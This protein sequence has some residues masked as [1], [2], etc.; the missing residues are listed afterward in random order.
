MRICAVMKYPPI[1][2]GVSARCYWLARALAKRGHQVHVVTNAGEVE[3]SYRIWICRRDRELLEASFDNGGRVTV[4][5]SGMRRRE[6]YHI[7]RSNP[8]ASKLAGLATEVVR[9]E[10]CDVLFSYYYEPYGLSGHLA[11]LWSGV[12]HV[13]QHAGS[14]QGRLLNHPELS[15]AYREMLRRAAMVV[16]PSHWLEG[17][18]IPPARLAR[19]GVN[20]LPGRHFYPE[21]TTMDVDAVLS[22]LAWHPFVRNTSPWRADL[23]TFG[24]LGKVA[25]LKGSY[26]LVAALARLRARGEE[27]NLLAMVAGADRDRFLAAVDDA[28][29]HQRTWTL[30]LLPHWHVPSFLRACTAVCFLERRFAIPAH[31][32]GIPQEILAC[33]VCAVLSGEI[34]EKQQFRRRLRAGENVLVVEDPTNLDELVAVL[35]LVVRDPDRARAMGA[36]GA[37]L[38]EADGEDELGKAYEALFQAAVEGTG[39]DRSATGGAVR[40]PGRSEDE[41]TVADARALLSRHAPATVRLMAPELGKALEKQRAARSGPEPA[42]PQVAYLAIDEVVREHAADDADPRLEF[43]RFERDV[44]WLAVDLEG[45]AGIPQFPRPAGAPALGP[46]PGGES[47]RPVRSNWLRISA[48]PEGIERA[49]RA[50]SLGA[51]ADL[52]DLNGSERVGYLFH[53]R[54]DLTRHVY[55]VNRATREL[56][57]LCNGSRTIAEIDA[58]LAQR[59]VRSQD[60]TAETIDR[61]EREG[62]LYLW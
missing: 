49:I 9:R 39:R 55:R 25:E 51:E 18:G 38:V 3:D 31:R 45:P 56:I 59:G 40:E 14:D 24:V 44:L 57:E 10:R 23:P 4:T 29:L 2:G 15:L 41:V 42:A 17:L 54:G 12:P 16:T 53:K 33:G 47:R 7:P 13:V 26:D 37:S 5:S 1:E 43:A 35:E 36:A 58:G 52:A 32:P 46:P 8:F 30:P 20:F 50:V 21:A 48:Y 62:I 22:E 60:R 6:T 28:G 34:A 11:S 61:L 19:V 27:F